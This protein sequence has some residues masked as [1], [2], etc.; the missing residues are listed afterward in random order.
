M[1]IRQARIQNYSVSSGLTGSYKVGATDH[2]IQC[3]F[4][5]RNKFPFSK[6]HTFLCNCS[7]W[8]KG[9]R[10]YSQKQNEIFNMLFNIFSVNEAVIARTF[11][12]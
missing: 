2:C 10:T 11:V 8:E 12:K 9:L 7:N 6:F 5:I 1:K 4:D 3:V